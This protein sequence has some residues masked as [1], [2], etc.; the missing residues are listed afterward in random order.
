MLETTLSV[1]KCKDKDACQKRRTMYATITNLNRISN[2][3]PSLLL[4]HAHIFKIYIILCSSVFSWF[5]WILNILAFS[6]ST[7][8]TYSN[9]EPK[10]TFLINILIPYQEMKL[11][12]EKKELWFEILSFNEQSTWLPTNFILGFFFI[13]LLRKGCQALE[14]AA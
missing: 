8:D 5:S 10:S 4:L 7:K 1:R 14:Q 2:S 9:V 12:E 3:L 13:F 6:A 11:K